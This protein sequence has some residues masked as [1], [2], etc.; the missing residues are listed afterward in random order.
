MLPPE[1]AFTPS[2]DVRQLLN[3]L[4]DR[5]ERRMTGAPTANAELRP[6]RSVKILISEVGL[7]G[8]ASQIDPEP[9]QVANEQLQALEKAGLLAEAS[10]VFRIHRG[11]AATATGHRAVGRV[12]DHV[13]IESGD[14]D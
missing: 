11:F 6:L 12:H 4:L 2:A 13:G 7:T 3:A 1:L 14:A 10:E 9:R 5:L 8:Y